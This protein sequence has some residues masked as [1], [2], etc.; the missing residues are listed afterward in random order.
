M[1]EF[2]RTILR[3]DF[4]V[5][6]NLL[7]KHII[8]LGADFHITIYFFFFFFGQFHQYHTQ[9]FSGVKLTQEAE[10]NFLHLTK[11]TNDAPLLPCPFLTNLCTSII[12]QYEK[13]ALYLR[14]QLLVY[15]C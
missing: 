3:S 11:S 7:L 8:A 1:K 6:F 14:Q 10:V 13:G 9:T 5:V 12:N 2:I 15:K 4:S